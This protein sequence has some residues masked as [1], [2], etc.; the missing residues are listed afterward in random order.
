MF[1]INGAAAM[2]YYHIVATVIAT[3]ER[4]WCFTWTRDPASGI[5]RAKTQA[6]LF[7]WNELL[8]DYRAEPIAE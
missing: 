4:F 7:G 3:G 6:L 8:T 1:V 5:A 2:R